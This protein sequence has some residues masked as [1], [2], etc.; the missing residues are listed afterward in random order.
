MDLNSI[1]TIVVS[2]VMLYTAIIWL[3]ARRRLI[4]VNMTII[5]FTLLLEGIVYG[6]F[7][8]Y[9]GYSLEERVLHSRAV[10]VVMCLSQSV[11]LTWSYIRSLYRG[12]NHS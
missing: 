3:V 8:Q 1:P 7:G 12:N 2:I 4:R 11:P 9:T 10:I 6:V 5:A